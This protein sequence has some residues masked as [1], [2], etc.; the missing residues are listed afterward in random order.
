MTTTS[1]PAPTVTVLEVIE[2]M[3]DRLDA[4]GLS[5]ADGYGQGTV[6]TGP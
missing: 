6:E 2:Q 4:A 5:F 3:A 1:I